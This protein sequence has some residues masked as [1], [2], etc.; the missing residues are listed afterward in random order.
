MDIK[1]DTKKGFDLVKKDIDHVGKWIKHL[2]S[3]K[4]F[5]KKDIEELKEILSSVQKDLEELKSSKT[6]FER[7]LEQIDDDL[8]L[9]NISTK[10]VLS[11]DNTKLLESHRLL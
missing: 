3:E 2:H 1:N 10:V 7:R 5:H 4:D 6:D 8:S 9:K 11:E